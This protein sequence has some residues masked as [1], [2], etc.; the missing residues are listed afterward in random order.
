MIATRPKSRRKNGPDIVDQAAATG[1]QIYGDIWAVPS[2]ILDQ[3]I[4][5]G[6]QF[7]D[8]VKGK[9]KHLVRRNSG[10]WNDES[11]V[12]KDLLFA[13]SRSRNAEELARI[14][15]WA[16][17]KR[18]R[19]LQDV[20]E[21]RA[22][23]LRIPIGDLKRGYPRGW[24]PQVT[25]RALRYRA[26]GTRRNPENLAAEAYKRFHGRPSEEE[27]IIKEEIH[28]HKDLA[29]LGV[30]AACVI[31]TPT[32]LRVTIEFDSDD[33]KPVP[34]LCMSEDGVQLFIE[35]GDQSIDLKPLEMDG[36]DWYKERMVLGTFA[37]PEGKRRWNLAYV[38]EK[39]FDQYETIRYEHDL[40][41]ANEGE[42]KSHRR[43]A[44]ALEFEPLNKKLFISG[45]QYKI[46][47][48]MIG[49]SPGIEN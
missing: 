14:H 20:C 13:A 6:L 26:N 24:N 15:K 4:K 41:E 1:M 39:S 48:P 2:A 9:V 43:E 34:W 46:K 47:L 37:P 16:I 23:E 21:A 10:T 28:Y 44:P 12:R 38:T 18:D 30:L 17:G 8:A 45:G 49:V 32:G 19:E 40:G 11:D 29:T 3:T 33:G 36:K 7:K 31:D 25:D 35:G 27:V 42:P 5:T 22:A